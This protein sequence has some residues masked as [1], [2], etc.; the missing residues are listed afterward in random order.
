MDSMPSLASGT[1]FHHHGSPNTGGGATGRNGGLFKILFPPDLIRKCS[2]PSGIGIHLFPHRGD[3]FLSALM[4][5]VGFCFL[6]D[7]PVDMGIV[8]DHTWSQ[9]VLIMRLTLTD[10]PE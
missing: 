9:V 2:K 10:S 7:L 8:N 4:G 3:D 5:E 1:R 6:N